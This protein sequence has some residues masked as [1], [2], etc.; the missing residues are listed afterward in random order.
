VVL[1]DQ[2]R[3]HGIVKK[4]ERWQG[5]AGWSSPIDGSW[6]C[7]MNRFLGWSRVGLRGL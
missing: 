3:D 2:G 4:G 6:W 1:A 5:A 7:L